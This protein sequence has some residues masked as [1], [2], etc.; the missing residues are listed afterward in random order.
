[1]NSFPL[2]EEKLFC[3]LQSLLL[4]FNGECDDVKLHVISSDIIH[5]QNT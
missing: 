2:V 3:A 4:I 5:W 1:M